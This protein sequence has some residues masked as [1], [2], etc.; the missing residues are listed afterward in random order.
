MQHYVIE[1]V[2]DLQQVDGFKI[3]DQTNQYI[4]ILTYIQHNYYKKSQV[5]PEVF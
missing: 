4:S 5:N 1:F 3:L 2:S